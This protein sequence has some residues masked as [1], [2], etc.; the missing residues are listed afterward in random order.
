M[1]TRV[2]TVTMRGRSV[3]GTAVV[4]GLGLT[5]GRALDLRRIEQKLAELGH[6]ERFRAVW[7]NPSGTGAAVSFSP[8]LEPA[9]DR[10]FGVG[11]A[12]D[13]F[14]S[15]RPWIGGIDRSL[16]G[17]VAEGVAIVRLGS[18]A[19]EVAGF[20]RLR[21]VV[22]RRYLPVAVGAWLAHESVRLFEGSGELPSAKTQE[23]GGFIGMRDE[24]EMA[25]IADAI[26]AG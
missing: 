3:D 13:Q 22:R 2:G 20:L 23:G 5:P 11:V 6:S 21:A 1:P 16:F 10:V 17:A 15:G 8:E 25:S 4:A 19:Q 24:Y 26:S 18:Y 14:M 12:F 9:P 7:L